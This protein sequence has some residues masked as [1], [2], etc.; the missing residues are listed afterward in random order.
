M[1]RSFPEASA[2]HPGG[3]QF[4]LLRRICGLDAGGLEVCHCSTAISFDYSHLVA[5]YLH[6][7]HTTACGQLIGSDAGRSLHDL[8]RDASEAVS[9]ENEDIPESLGRGIRR[10]AT[11]PNG[12]DR[13]K[14][15][16]MFRL[17]R[18]GSRPTE[19]FPGEPYSQQ[20]VVGFYDIDDFSPPSGVSPRFNFDLLS[21]F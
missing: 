16:L 19:L 17:D 8:E 4:S 3:L 20:N 2:V 9:R 13:G 14:Q 7:D 5:L 12:L 18:A 11:L 15:G 21:D 1:K 6:P 10:R